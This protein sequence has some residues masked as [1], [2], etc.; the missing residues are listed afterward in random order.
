MPVCRGSSLLVWKMFPD[1]LKPFAGII[2]APAAFYNMGGEQLRRLVYIAVQVGRRTISTLQECTTCSVP[3]DAA[4]FDRL[5]ERYFP[6]EQEKEEKEKETK[7][8]TAEMVVPIEMPSNLP[9]VFSYGALRRSFLS[10]TSGCAYS[11]L[12]IQLLKVDCE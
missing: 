9:S 4:Y 11:I 12:A 7:A 3:M 1:S 6:D 2:G 8:I 5:I 10:P